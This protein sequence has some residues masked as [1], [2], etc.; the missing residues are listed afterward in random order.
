MRIV[1][2]IN[3]LIGGGAERVCVTLADQ[4]TR[5]GHQVCIATRE[6]V[7]KDAYEVNPAVERIVLAG[8][9]SG[10]ALA[11]NFRDPLAVRRL[12]REVAADAVISFMQMTNIRTTLAL[13]GTGVP[14]VIT[15]HTDPLRAKLGMFW[16]ALRRLVY[17][18][19][20]MLVSVGKGVDQGF[21]WLSQV[22]RRVIYNP[23]Q[24][25]PPP[26]DAAN[27][28]E[29]TQRTIVAMGRLVPVKGFDLLIEA[30]SD[31]A[32]NHLD[33]NLVILGE[34]KSRE[35]LQAQID[36][37]GLA[38]RVSLP[39]FVSNPSTVLYNS[40]LFVLSSRWEGFALAP[41][42]AM[43]AGLAV[44]SFDC[45]SGPRELIEH[46]RTGLLVE[47]ENVAAL[48]QAME[49]LIRDEGERAKLGEAARDSILERFDADRIGDQWDLLLNDLC[50]DRIGK[51]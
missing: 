17:P 45:R 50:S 6:P 14:V 51:H 43:A 26:D 24:I 34:G 3:S 46:E 4:L 47:P 9:G 5:H 28:R 30:F 2:V 41:A 18:F 20:T 11:R 15:E 42:E 10:G 49:R 35:A 25:G 36:S 19:A 37:N 23:I 48:Q 22:R 27:K 8:A 44:I 33:W 39:G 21:R 32:R 40:D 31:V 12:V 29:Y 38:Q 16:R 13:L 1:M 7:S